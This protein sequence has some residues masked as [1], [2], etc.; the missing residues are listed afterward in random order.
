MAFALKAMATGESTLVDITGLDA[1]NTK[2]T[3]LETLNQTRMD[4]MNTVNQRSHNLSLTNGTGPSIIL[5]N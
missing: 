5:L 3:V 1:G 4:T 2:T